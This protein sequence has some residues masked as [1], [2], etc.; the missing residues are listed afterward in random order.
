ME[1]STAVYGELWPFVRS[2]GKVFLS[3]FAAII[4]VV[5]VF[6]L[7]S[8]ARILYWVLIF[9]LLCLLSLCLSLC[10][11]YLLQILKEVFLFW[12]ITW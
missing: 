12:S 2:T 7:F 5:V 3:L 6:K 11:Y 1:N 10:V 9:T 4:V 8:F